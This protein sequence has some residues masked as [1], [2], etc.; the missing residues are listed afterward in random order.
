M[1][2]S[3]GG[4]DLLAAGVVVT[5]EVRVQPPELR[6]AQLLACHQ[7]VERRKARGR[8]A[9]LQQR[10]AREL[11]VRVVQIRER[12]R[13]AVQRAVE[14]RVAACIVRRRRLGEPQAR[15]VRQQGGARLRAVEHVRADPIPAVAERDRIPR[16][17]DEPQRPPQIV[18]G[19]GLPGG[20]AVDGVAERRERALERGLRLIGGRVARQDHVRR[21]L[22]LELAGFEAARELRNGGAGAGEQLRAQARRAILAVEDA[23]ERG[24]RAGL[25]PE[26]LDDLG[27]RRDDE[28]AVVRRRAGALEQPHAREHRRPLPEPVDRQQLV[29]QLG[30]TLGV[31]VLG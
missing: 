24:S 20:R 22:E 3:D 14:D 21:A 9:S 28:R 2:E 30:E 10:D 17:G 4:G 13:G 18:L 15:G 19:P 7:L 31:L 16:V 23:H 26:L 12:V 1:R 27:D 29:A 6:S 5:Q 11:R 25:D 8:A